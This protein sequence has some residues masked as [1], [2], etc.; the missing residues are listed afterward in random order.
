[1]MGEIGDAERRLSALPDSEPLP[2]AAQLQVLLGDAKAV[3]GLAHD[4]QACPRAS[5]SGGASTQ[6]A[7]R[8]LQSR[9]GE[10]RLMKVIQERGSS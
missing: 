10:A 7:L 9:T 2:G 6:A 3:F 8:L 5:V 4:R 1:M